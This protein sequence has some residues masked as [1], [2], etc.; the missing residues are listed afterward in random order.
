MPRL[1]PQLRRC[2]FP[3]PACWRDA[4]R[5]R[6]SGLPLSAA[7]RDA[8]PLR[9]STG[10]CSRSHRKEARSPAMPWLGPEWLLAEHATALAYV[11]PHD[12][13]LEV[14]AGGE[15]HAAARRLGQ[16]LGKAHV[17]VRLRPA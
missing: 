17:F 3:V 5:F 7:V 8:P 13:A 6:P 2:G 14:F 9:R 15:E 4:G 12:I 1:R 11:I 10:R 16:L